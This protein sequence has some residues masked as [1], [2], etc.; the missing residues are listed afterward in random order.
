[1]NITQAQRGLDRHR[2]DVY[3]VVHL[4]GQASQVAQQVIMSMLERQAEVMEKVAGDTT[5]SQLSLA[6]EQSI[7][8][9]A[10]FHLAV[11]I[12]DHLEA[13][14]TGLAERIQGFL[15]PLNDATVVGKLNIVGTTIGFHSPSNW[16]FSPTIPNH[17][18]AFAQQG[19]ARLL[20][21]AREESLLGHHCRIKLEQI[22]ILKSVSPL[23]YGVLLQRNLEKSDAAIIE[24]SRNDGVETRQARLGQDE[25][26]SDIVD[27]GEASA[28]SAA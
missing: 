28:E 3:V 19:E 15:H 10:T 2:V 26:D 13:N 5:L 22:F 11:A 12:N 4:N 25:Q 23:G 21:H 24:R 18:L 1:M 27:A 17:L 7:T 16:Y 20:A 6:K 14:L 9:A 8:Q